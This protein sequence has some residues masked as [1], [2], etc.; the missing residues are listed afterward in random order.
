M[1]NLAH[2]F[3]VAY[4]SFKYLLIWGVNLTRIQLIFDLNIHNI[5]DNF[6]AHCGRK[7]V[8]G[9]FLKVI[10]IYMEQSLVWA[11]KIVFGFVD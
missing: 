10:V 1:V 2:S 5:K 9:L 4:T 8:K 7:R 3:N 6:W 11:S